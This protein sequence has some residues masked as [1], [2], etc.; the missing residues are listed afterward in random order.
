MTLKISQE[1]LKSM[2]EVLDYNDFSE[3]KSYN[4]P[5]KLV[6]ESFQ[7]LNVIIGNI[8]KE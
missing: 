8:T 3:L 4:S 7:A 2:I 6:G 1:E 5:P